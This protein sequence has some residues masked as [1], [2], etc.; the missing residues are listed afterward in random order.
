MNTPYKF[1]AWDVLNERMLEWKDIFHLP[2]WEIFPGT[3]EQRPFI[4]RSFTGYKD[5]SGNEIYRGD[6]ILIDHGDNHKWYE[7]VFFYQGCYMAGE[8]N[9]LANVV[10]NAKVVGNIYE[11][12]ELLEAS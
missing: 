6:I 2:A 11:N 3:P 7:E 10:D 9:L 8:E 4:I 1:Q 12:P 5:T